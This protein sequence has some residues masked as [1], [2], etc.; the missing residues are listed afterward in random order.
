MFFMNY[1][2]KSYLQ[3]TEMFQS[4]RNKNLWHGLFLTRPGMICLG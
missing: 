1:E 3:F 4:Y 2:Q